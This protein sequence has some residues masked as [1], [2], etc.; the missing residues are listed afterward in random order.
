MMTIYQADTF[1]LNLPEPVD[2]VI[3][4]PPMCILR[5]D[6]HKLFKWVEQSLSPEGI[7]IL[8][9]PAMYNEHNHN[10]NRYTVSLIEGQTDCSLKSRFALP[11]YDFYQ[12]GGIDSLYFYSRISLE[13]LTSI[14]YRKCDERKMAHRC[15]FDAT[16]I[17]NLI[18]K[19]SQLGQTVLDPFCRTGTVPRVA[20]QLKRKGIGID[21]RCPY[22]NED[23]SNRR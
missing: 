6:L 18:K 23:P 15:E 3:T 4:S 5:G 2:L 8:E 17:G 19:F 10:L 16:L 13:R 14:D 21:K 22:T 12:Q 1:D 7:F 11:L 9:C 20:H